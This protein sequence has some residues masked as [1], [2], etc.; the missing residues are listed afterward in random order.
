VA[1]QTLTVSNLS[2][3][4]ALVHSPRPLPPNSVH[5]IE[6]ESVSEA[7]ILQARVVRTTPSHGSGYVVALEFVE[8]P[9]AAL[10]QILRMLSSEAPHA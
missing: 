1:T 2:G 10:E 8:P 9:P 5:S 7:V 6:L 4:G 3:G